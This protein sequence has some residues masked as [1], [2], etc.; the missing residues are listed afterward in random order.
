MV[1]YKI[2]C[3]CG[4]SKATIDSKAIAVKCFCHCETCRTVANGP[5]VEVVVVQPEGLEEEGDIKEFV[6]SDL[7]KIHFC[8]K[9]GTKIYNTNNLGLKVVS[10]QLLRAAGN[11]LEKDHLLPEFHLHYSMR[12]CDFKDGLPKFLDMPADFGGSG[13]MYVEG[14]GPHVQVA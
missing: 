7:V 1:M 14:Q 10:D 6:K 11:D 9:C 12:V 2:H 4:A 5:A 8:G 13:K 3:I